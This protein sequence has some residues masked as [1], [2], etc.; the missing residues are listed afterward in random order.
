MTH[1]KK[2]A[3]PPGPPEPVDIAF[4]EDAVARLMGMYDAY[5]DFY[6]FYNP[7]TRGHVSVLSNPDHAK[8]LLITHYKKYVKGFGNDR[9]KILMGDGLITLEGERWARQ[10]RMIQ[11]A[12]HRTILS[13]FLPMVREKNLQLLDKWRGVAA[14]GG[15]VNVDQDTS[16]MTLAVV[17]DSILSE[18]LSR[19]CADHGENP[20]L[21][22]A[23]EPT[24]DLQFALR[25]RALNGIVQDT[26]DQ[27]RREDRR[28]FDFL[29]MLMDTRDRATGEPMTDRQM[30]DEVMTLI[31]AGHETTATALTW[32]WYLLSQHPEAAARVHQEV[33]AIP[34]DLPM[35][36]ENV[37]QLTYTRQV[38]D[39]SLRLYPPAW[40]LT[41][42]AVAAD[43]IGGCPIDDGSHLFASPYMVHRNPAFWPDPERFD[44]DRF[45][46]GADEGRHMC[47]YIP[48]GA[49]PRRCIG[50]QL[51]ILEMQIH[52]FVM[53]RELDLAYLCDARPALESKVNLRPREAIH[54]R[55][56]RAG[57]TKLFLPFLSTPR[58][59]TRHPG[60]GPR[61]RA[62]DRLRRDLHR[63][64]AQ[65]TD[66]LLR[67]DPR[68][69]PRAAPPLPGKGGRTRHGDDSPP[70]R[71]RA[72]R[73]RV[74]GVPA[75]P[76]RRGAD[77]GR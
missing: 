74:L 44:P 11:P 12:F 77:R 41:R 17:L 26:I 10:R 3:Y 13:R 72:V 65:R 47:A 51:A 16:D 64:R 75:R 45:A 37:Q 31:I 70:R 53:A 15:I 22:V 9:V 61:R 21:L 38:I 7:S 23:E 14:L 46:P 20:F 36:V 58:D 29:S 24:R 66:G 1:H 19:I 60:R 55:P 27:R 18:D 39:E 28:P 76:H 52:F 33:R 5:G 25:F 35:T 67:A 30:V 40:M 54:M 56:T 50:E 42:R 4:S 49:G 8:Q 69:C 32:T 43:R 73:R 68:T 71:Q 6:R 59:E 34:D 48:F 62:Q 2:N 63:R 57:V